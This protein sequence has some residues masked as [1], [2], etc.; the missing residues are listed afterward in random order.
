MRGIGY[1]EYVFRANSLFDPNFT[2]GGHQ[3]KGFDQLTAFYSRFR[4]YQTKFQLLCTP[5]VVGTPG[6]LLTAVATNSS[7]SFSNQ[8]AAAET[9]GAQSTIITDQEPGRITGTI[10]LAQLNGKSK[11]QYATDDFTAGSA[12][13]DPSEVLCLHVSMTNLTGSAESIN[14]FLNMIFHC[15]FFDPTQ[16]AQS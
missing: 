5:A 16:L 14:I 8:G 4:V 2:G 1:G 11:E 6:K 13:A 7:T 3:P 10:D 9:Y 15:E 12:T